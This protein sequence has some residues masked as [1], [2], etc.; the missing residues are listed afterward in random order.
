MGFRVTD[1]LS[2]FGYEGA[3]I[4]E[5]KYMLGNF[6]LD[7]ANVII[8]PENSVNRDIRDMRTNGYTLKINDATILTIVE[9]G[10]NVYNANGELSHRVEDEIIDPARW[11]EYMA[12]MNECVIHSIEK[13]ENVYTIELD[14]EDHTFEIKVRGESDEESWDRFL[15]T[16]QML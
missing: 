13:E 16:A 11:Y 12:D 9:E 15:S 10:Y 5:I 3:V 4:T 1:E 14:T 6:Y 8:K 7:L 2:H